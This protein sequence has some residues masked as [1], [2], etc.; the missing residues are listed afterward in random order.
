M[1]HFCLFLLLAACSA[2]PLQARRCA[3]PPTPDCDTLLTVDGRMLLVHVK[4]V[5]ANQVI[6]SK[7]GPAV[8]GLEY[9]LPRN[10]VKEIRLSKQ[11]AL[12]GIYKAWV[13]TK[14]ASKPLKGYV[15]TTT[16]STLFLVSNAKSGLESGAGAREIPVRDI[17]KI[18]FRKKSRVVRSTLSGFAI[19]AG[20]GLL[21]G[22]AAGGD[23][24]GFLSL[25]A[26]E[27]AVIGGVFLGVSGA[28]V[29]LVCGLFKKTIRIDGSLDQ[30]RH[31]RE[32]IQQHTLSRR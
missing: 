21:G 19:G 2:G 31:F 32:I 6:Y 17:K 7:C 1:K 14:T 27:K 11:S 18:Q 8:S 5:N 16:D 28:I 15:L 4:E 30:Y 12:K 23:T 29:G 25:T 24:P 10:A 26:G 20:I 9:A 22:F 13:Y 3:L